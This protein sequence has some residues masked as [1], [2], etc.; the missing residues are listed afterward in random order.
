MI[1]VL[2]GAVVEKRKEMCE[3]P[4]ILTPERTTGG[5][6]ERQD[7]EAQRRS[8]LCAAEK[9]GLFKV[10]PGASRQIGDGRKRSDQNTQG[11]QNR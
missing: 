2:F 10:G 7:M 6:D 11:K 5:V 3:K 4:A 8:I 1:G 9:L